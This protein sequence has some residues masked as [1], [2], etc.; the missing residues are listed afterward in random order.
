LI[1][2]GNLIQCGDRKNKWVAKQFISSAEIIKVGELYDG[3]STIQQ[4][5]IFIT[6]N[7][8]RD[9]FLEGF[10]D[11]ENALKCME[12]FLDWWEKK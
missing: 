6:T 1:T 3:V 11:E 2:R 5:N 7:P 8:G 12:E 4:Y 9:M 10:R